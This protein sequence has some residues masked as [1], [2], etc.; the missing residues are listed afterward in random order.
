MVA[1][2]QLDVRQRVEDELGGPVADNIWEYLHNADRIADQNDITRL[3]EEV[4]NAQRAFNLPVQGEAAPPLIEEDEGS[5]ELRWQAVS[6]LLAKE[7]AKDARVRAFRDRFLNGQTLPHSKV[8]AWLKE[9]AE[10][11]GPPRP[12]MTAP[13]VL[14][15]ADGKVSLI[16]I[17]IKQEDSGPSVRVENRY[18]EYGIPGHP[19]RLLQPIAPG[20]V[21]EKLWLLIRDLRRT[22]RLWTPAQTTLFILSGL[23]PQVQ[24]IT[25][26]VEFVPGLQAATRIVITVDPAVTPDDLADY[27][28][29]ARAE[30]KTARYRAISEK[31]LQLA[32]FMEQASELDSW[33]IRLEEWNRQFPE[34]SYDNG[35]E[36]QRDARKVRERLLHPQYE[37]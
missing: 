34:Y 4:R 18:I 10:R 11:D 36:F 1:T 26:R 12:W 29:K 21:L 17:G 32:I 2:Y 8:E 24:G 33:E 13:V 15:D 7:A 28:A 5:A 6:L 9:Q 37:V 22:Y 23:T 31:H 16:G 19:W 35:Y 27:Y 25:H 20:G 30:L 3:V 14:K